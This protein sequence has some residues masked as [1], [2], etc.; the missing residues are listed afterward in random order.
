M[1]KDCPVLI[2]ASVKDKQ[3]DIELKFAAMFTSYVWINDL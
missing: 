1:P 3:Q 2:H